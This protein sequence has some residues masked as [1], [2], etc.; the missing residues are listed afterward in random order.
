[1]A[2]LP[3]VARRLPAR[4]WWQMVPLPPR[5]RAGSP[6]HGKV[7]ACLDAKP[8]VPVLGLSLFARCSPAAH[9]RPK[10]HLAQRLT[11]LF[12]LRLHVAYLL[13]QKRAAAGR[14]FLAPRGS[15]SASLL[16]RRHWPRA[17]AASTPHRAPVRR[18][19]PPPVARG[20]H[21]PDERAVAPRALLP[22]VTSSPE[23]VQPTLLHT[24]GLGLEHGCRWV[25]WP[26]R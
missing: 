17:D 1:M 11:V 23:F 25:P 8:K 26:Y 9:L 12:A 7:W 16:V 20:H 14:Y 19:Q 6:R 24:P 10:V 21:L 5:A 3:L 13:A 15:E 18:G 2:S 4:R 22:S